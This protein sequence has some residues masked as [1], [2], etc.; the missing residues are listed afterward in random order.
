[1]R[2]KTL[3]LLRL[4]GITVNVNDGKVTGFNFFK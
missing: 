1:M 4:L 2:L 3:K